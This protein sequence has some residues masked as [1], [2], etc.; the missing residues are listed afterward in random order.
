MNVVT[1]HCRLIERKASR[2]TPAGLLCQEALVSVEPP[3]KPAFEVSIVGF[4]EAAAQL[5]RA[6][7]GAQF[8]V[9]GQLQRVSLRSS[10]LNILIN[11]IELIESR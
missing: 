3:G 4:D 10:K 8:A 1:L 11:R 7:L 2:Y 9:Q 5:A 6:E